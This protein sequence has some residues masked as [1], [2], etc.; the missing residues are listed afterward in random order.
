MHAW[1]SQPFVPSR[2]YKI[3]IISTYWNQCYYSNVTMAEQKGVNNS[4]TSGGLSKDKS[5]SAFTGIFIFMV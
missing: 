3:T 1:T 4:M 5:I 2:V